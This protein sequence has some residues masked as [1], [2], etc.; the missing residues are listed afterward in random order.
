M[1]D[2]D[3]DEIVEQG[4]EGVQEHGVVD[5]TRAAVLGGSASALAIALAEII[6][7]IPGTLLAPVRAFA[8]GMAAF[9][10]GSLLAPVRVT[11][12]GATASVTSFLEGTGALLGP[13][14]FPVAVAV[15]IAGTWIFI[16]FVQNVVSVNPG[17]LWRRNR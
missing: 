12:A 10:E 7:G 17:Q 6:L 13:F 5:Y 15:A 2:Y 11:D 3:A 14:A 16:W 4:R 8:S 1:S 9:I